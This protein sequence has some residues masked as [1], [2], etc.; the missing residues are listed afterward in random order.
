MLSQ[1]ILGIIAILALGFF[2]ALISVNKQVAVIRQLC[3]LTSI[4]A[5]FV[6]VLA[7]VV[8]DKGAIGYQFARSFSVVTEYNLAFMIGVDG[9]SLI[10]LMLT[11][12][13]FPAMFLSAWTVTKTPKHFFCYL[14]GM[15]LLLVLTFAIIDLFYFFVLFESLLIPMFI[16]IGVWGARNRRIKAAYYFFLYTLFG[17]LFMLFGMIYLH[18]LVGSLN[19]YAILSTSLTEFDQE[20]VWLCFFLAFAVKMPLFPFHIWLPEAHVEA[21]TVGSMLLASLLLKLGGYGFLRFSLT[22]LCA[23]SET[24]LPLVSALA[25]AGVIYGSLS[26]LRQID[27]KRIIAYS[28]VSHMNLTV[29]GL[30]SFTQ[31]GL[32]G[33][34]YLMVAHGFVS[35]A[36]FFCVGVL[37]DR[38]HSR[39]LRYYG[40]LVVVMP[41]LVTSFFVFSLANMAFP[42]TPNFLGE[43][44][45]FQG[46]FKVSTVVLLFSTAG[47]VLAAAFSVFLFNRIAFGTLKTKYISEFTDANRREVTI[48]IMLGAVALLLGLCGDIV[49]DYAHLPVEGIVQN[50]DAANTTLSGTVGVP[51]RVQYTNTF[52]TSLPCFARFNIFITAKDSLNTLSVINPTNLLPILLMLTHLLTLTYTS[53]EN[54]LPGFEITLIPVFCSITQFITNINY[55]FEGLFTYFFYSE[56][57]FYI[58]NGLS[59][60]SIALAPKLR[61]KLATTVAWPLHVRFTLI[62]LSGL[63]AIY[64]SG[65]YTNCCLAY[66][67]VVNATNLLQSVQAVKVADCFFLGTIAVGITLWLLHYMFKKE[68]SQHIFSRGIIATVLPSNIH[69]VPGATSKSAGGD[70]P[71]YEIP[72][73]WVGQAYMLI[74]FAIGFIVCTTSRHSAAG[75]HLIP[76]VVYYCAYGLFT[77]YVITY[78]P[79]FIFL[80]C[81][82]GFVHALLAGELPITYWWRL[83]KIL[84]LSYFSPIIDT[85]HWLCEEMPRVF[86]TGLIFL[87]SALASYWL[88]DI[89]PLGGICDTVNNGIKRFFL[90]VVAWWKPKWSEQLFILSAGTDIAIY[91]VSWPWSLIVLAVTIIILIRD[92]P[93]KINNRGVTISLIAIII[94]FKILAVIAPFP[95]ACYEHA[96]SI[97]V[98]S[99]KRYMQFGVALSMIAR[100]AIKKWYIRVRKQCADCLL[101][102]I[103]KAFLFYARVFSS[104]VP[105]VDLVLLNPVVVK[106]RAGAR[107]RRRVRLLRLE[108]FILYV[109]KS[110][111]LMLTIWWLTILSGVYVVY[112]I[113]YY[114]VYWY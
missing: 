15:E 7:C 11:L 43:V 81:D 32:D 13:T 87:N 90:K 106:W 54:I 30:F 37:Y 76:T 114:L 98:P 28:S 109:I 16:M 84:T 60:A 75:K 102:Y 104:M 97:V 95:I 8:F 19:Y 58:E 99:V 89:T 1:P 47:I 38:T 3:L 65:S 48:I 113:V 44:L 33:A 93:F 91:Q 80:W 86:V 103:L 2:L 6:G 63:L 83:V 105:Y 77:I 101:R 100:E 94:V 18:Q 20:L 57:R 50:F 9:L 24:F 49:L 79:Q 71:I 88:T 64:L 68:N 10:F 31:E 74:L 107:T 69:A 82:R 27:L 55:N 21:P 52:G 73:I 61:R 66:E 36:L 5:L 39:L 26:T 12:F 62:M 41:L 112:C 42:G 23:A 25:L 96:A 29:L 72:N 35:A 110:R 34:I 56:T 45:V 40:G 85:I 14:L 111:R 53:L 17:S 78:T 51:T 59:V 67:D 108:R 92:V 70:F 22:F 46:V 4:A